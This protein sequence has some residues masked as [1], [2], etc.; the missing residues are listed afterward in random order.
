VARNSPDPYRNLSTRN[1]PQTERVTG[2]ADQVQ[3][4]AGGFVFAIDPYAQ[5]RRFLVLGSVGGTF[6]VS[7][8]KLTADNAA[9]VTAC[10]DKDADATLAVIREISVEGRAPKQQ[11]TMLALA[12][13]A[14]HPDTAVRTKALALLPEVCRTGTML[15]TFIT[16]V[17]QFR[18]WGRGLRNAIGNWYLSQEPD[19]L[20]YGMVKYQSREGWSHR[21]VLRLAKP[22]PERESTM[23]QTFAWATG[24]GD[25][26]GVLIIDAFKRAHQ[27]GT[28]VK[29]L[30][31]LIEDFNLS[32]EML[33]SEALAKPEIWSAL[34]PKMG[35]GA[36]VRNLGRMSANGAL[37]PMSTTE[38]TIVSR[39]LDAEDVRRSRIHPMA[40]LLAE[41][42]YV[43]GRGFKGSL[44]WDPSTKV[45]EAL[46]R[47]FKL[48]F[49]NVEP[50]G[51]RT[52]IGLDVS[53]SMSSHIGGTFLS[54]AEAGAAMSIITAATEPQC[55]IMGF[56]NDF[57]KLPI[58]GSTNLSDAL[59]STRAMNF[60]ST[61]CAL[62]MV[63][64]TKNQVDVDTFLVITDS[65][66]YAGRPHPFQ[67]LQEYR[68][69]SG[70]DAKMVVMAMT[71]SGFSIADPSDAGMLDV[72]GFDAATP[73]LVADFSAGRL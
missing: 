20:A 4:N 6:Y 47:T 70:N 14:S 8:R 31:K 58:T 32:W 69:K 64:A 38:A 27:P 45:V 29:V 54:C 62:P 26:S 59:R 51:K 15:F 25:G 2:R 57:R 42:T 13:A 7:E 3:N 73:A 61:D 48:A 37:K 72:V 30:I 66:T 9:V 21:D 65:E 50:A 16:Y 55:Q 44:S 5:L 22:R 19:R 11:P 68:R 46:Q 43:A 71:S 24:K 52:L 10:L 56:A 1:T 63:W 17:E 39:L 18:G 49:R 35:L 12:I 34:V 28:S 40:V 67:A 33:P 23:D 60:G 53:G 36:L 41:R